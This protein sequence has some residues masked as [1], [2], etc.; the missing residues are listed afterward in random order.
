MEEEEPVACATPGQLQIR[1]RKFQRG[2]PVGRFEA[3]L[4]GTDHDRA[5]RP[6][7]FEAIMEGSAL[8]FAQDSGLYKEADVRPRQS[9]RRPYSEADLDLLRRFSSADLRPS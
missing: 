3:D 1:Q 8:V 2:R 5:G 7:A 6:S 4:R 9:F